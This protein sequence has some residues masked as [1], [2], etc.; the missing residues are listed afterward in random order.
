M[1]YKKLSRLAKTDP[2][3]GLLN[4]R[5]LH[6][7]AK[8]I[9]HLAARNSSTFAVLSIDVDYFKYV[10]GTYNH[11]TGDTVLIHLANLLST[12]RRANDLAART[13]DEEFVLIL[14]DID[15]ENSLMLAEKLRVAVENASVT[16]INITISIRLVVSQKDLQVD[17][18]SL[19]TLSDKALYDA[20]AGGRNQAA[21][22]DYPADLNHH[23]AQPLLRLDPAMGISRFGHRVKSVDHSPDL[24]LTEH[25][26]QALQLF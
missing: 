9:I 22:I 25:L 18:D 2:L 8:K 1:Q 14:A 23:T 16:I 24:A 19:L 20:K 13:G 3:T 26:L 6:K 15:K 17:L 21:L 12:E 10:N 4:R 5:E 7:Q 11:Q